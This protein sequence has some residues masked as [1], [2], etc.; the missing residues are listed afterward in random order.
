MGVW[1]LLAVAHVEPLWIASHLR[2]SVKGARLIHALWEKLRDVGRSLGLT[3][4][5]SVVPEGVTEHI[6]TS[7]G[8]VPLPGALYLVSFD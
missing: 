4:A 8:A 3:K 2:N 1:C 7:L 5:V 6:A